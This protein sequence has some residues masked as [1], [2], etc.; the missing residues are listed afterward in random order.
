MRASKIAGILLVAYLITLPGALHQHAWL[1][2]AGVSLAAILGVMLLLGF[3]WAWWILY[4][5]SM[6]VI[7][8]NIVLLCVQPDPAL[9]PVI[10]FW[11]VLLLLVL[12]DP[13]PRFSEWGIKVCRSVATYA[14]IY[15]LLLLGAVIFSFPFVWMACTSVKVDRE[16]FPEKFTLLPMAPSPQVKSPFIDQKY[17]EYR[18]LPAERRVASILAALTGVVRDQHI[19][20]PADISRTQAEEMITRALYKRLSLRLAPEV[21]EGSTEKIAAAGKEL[22]T[23]EL[24]AEFFSNV[25]RRL[26]LGLLTARSTELAVERLGGNTPYSQR[27]DNL[28]PKVA[29]LTDTKAE[30][31]PVAVVSYNFANGNTVRLSKTFTLGFKATDLQ[32]LQLVMR[33]DDTW[34]TLWLTV[35]RNG[36]K[37]V[38]ERPA[39]L[40]NFTS[41]T[42]T[43]QEYGP[44]DK[45]LKEKTWI[46]LKPVEGAVSTVTDPNQLK[47]T[48]ELR[49][50]SL[51]EALWNKITRNYI[52]TLDQIPF[53]RY[54]RNSLFVVITSILLAT[55][56][57]SLVGYAFARLNW[58]G[59]DFCFLLML[60]TMMIPGQVT[61]IPHFLIWKSVGAY[62]TLTPL[63]LGSAFGSAFFIFLIRQTLKGIPHDLEDAARIDGCGFWRIYWNIMLPLIRPSLAA[64][65][66][67]TFMGS[68]N[69]FMGPLIYIFD[70]RLY[71][72]AFG[73]FAFSIQI[74]GNFALTMAGSLL[75]TLPVIIIFFFA[76]KYFIQG[77]TLTGMK[78]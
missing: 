52:T 42:V 69:D 63:W 33:P 19:V 34:H 50:S 57:S 36:K 65:A 31:D 9:F 32:Q 41:T 60:A 29:T 21:W 20:L 54:V 62:D 35:E 75:M 68:W 55:F 70:Q 74:G 38:A 37:F 58:P 73:L 49:R 27:M 71:T 53:W 13:L 77:V 17:P 64:I 5:T 72:L 14:P 61:M 22:L 28:T 7:I 18:N 15:L 11:F 76:Q 12:A 8:W 24:A 30:N 46:V 45:A 78:G 3:R 67:F 39:V 25:Y 56:I 16:L 66:I 47:L 6:V 10:I 43:W 59:R 40:A 51:R 2:S 1:L 26:E 4:I 23:P 44:D 48:F